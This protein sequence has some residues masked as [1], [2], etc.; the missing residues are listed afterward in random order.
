[1]RLIVCGATG[2]VGARLADRATARFEVVRTSSRPLEGAWDLDLA[3]AHRFDAA[4]VD[5]QDVLVLAAA[6]SSPD[7]CERDHARAWAVNVAGTSQVIERVRARGARVIFLSSDTVY[8]EQAEP[9]DEQMPCNPAG[10]YAEMKRAVETR[11]SGDPGFHSLR[12][13]YVFSAADRFTAYLRGCASRGVCA[14]IFD[15]FVRSVVYR[16]DVVDTILAMALDWPALQNGVLNVGG[17]EALSRA[18]YASTLR[19]VAWPKLAFQVVEPDELFFRNRPRR[20][21]MLSPGLPALLGRSPLTLAAATAAE[22]R[23]LEI[24]P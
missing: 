22:Q 13:S 15:P 16:E 1:M 12:L 5:A 23:S 4:R 21:A 20:I 18:A 14:E 7:L 3:Q 10:P 19:D 24:T 8:G 6:I 17:P 9:F 11:F 2:Y